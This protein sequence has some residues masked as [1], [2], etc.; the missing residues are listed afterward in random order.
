MN[1]KLKAFF[2]ESLGYIAVALVSLIYILAG[3]FVPGLKGKSIYTI[4]AE[5]VTGFILGIS[6]NY[7]LKLQGILKGKNSKEM[8][9]TR[10]S[11]G[12]AV[13]RVAPYIDGLDTWCEE[14]NA[15]KLRQK[16]AQILT[17]AGMRYEEY[18]DANGL[19]RPVETESLSKERKRALRRALRAKITPLSTASLTCDGERSDDP[20]DFGET[21]E[22][23]Q[24]RTNLTDALSKVLTAAVFG[25]FGMDIVEGFD[26]AMLAWR[27]LYVALM[28]AL[29]VAKLVGAYLFVIDTY[30]GNIV[31]KINHLQSYEN[32]AEQYARRKREEKEHGKQDVQSGPIQNGCREA[33]E[34]KAA[35]RE[36]GGRRELPKADEVPAAA[37]GGAEHRH[38]RDRQNR[39]EQLLSKG[40]GAGGQRLRQR[41]DGSAQQLPHGKTGGGREG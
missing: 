37:D 30:R 34:A 26:V 27:A 4:I 13:N 18:F 14:Q 35:E 36:A 28:L 10:Q 17:D 15:T 21:P 31:K 29:G 11:H 6:V 16:R 7:N 41:H 33:V 23:Y 9:A 38:D 24:R 19:L 39:G 5:G 22:Q 20:F 2:N 32:C 12:E 8:Q 3:L 25:Y 40:T 1:D